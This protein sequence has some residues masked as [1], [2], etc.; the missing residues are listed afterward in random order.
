MNSEQ[1]IF[2]AGASA[3]QCSQLC[4][5]LWRTLPLKAEPELDPAKCN[6]LDAAARQLASA[7]TALQ[8]LSVGVRQPKIG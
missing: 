6:Q 5:N 4:E 1:L 7:A 8:R 3:I 2:A